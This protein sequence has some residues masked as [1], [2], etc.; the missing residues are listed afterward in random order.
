VADATARGRGPRLFGTLGRWI[1]R[2]PWYPIAFW[3]AL[4]IVAVP[5]L[6]LLGSVTTNS[7]TSLPATAP[8]S[9]ADR[10]LAEL[11]P[12]ESGGSS[13]YLLFTGPNLTD[14]N[15]QS[16]I[17]T[18][19]A[20]LQAD[21]K[22]TYVAG[23]SSVYTTYASYLG[24]EARI[25]SGAVQ[26]AAPVLVPSVNLSSTLLWGPPAL[27]L[28]TWQGL[29]RNGTSPAAANFPAYQE[30]AAALANQTQPLEVL[31]AFYVGYGSSGAG[32]NGSAQC[33]RDPT[34]TAVVACTDRTTRQNVGPLIGQLFPPDPSAQAVA[35]AALA[36][37]GVEN[38]T[39]YP[40][41]RATVA[42]LLV[43][44][45][46]LP[47]TWIDTVWTEFPHGIASPA[48]AAGW[49]NATVA[50]SS[51]YA[52]PLPI[53]YSISAQYVDPTGTASLIVVSFSVDD[54][55]TAPGGA[56]PVYNDITEINRIVPPTLAAADPS[57]AISFV[58]TGGSALDLAQQ[59]VLNQ[60]LGLV[61]PITVVLLMAITAL[62][63]RAPITPL[64]AF[65]G[66][67]IALVLSLGSTVLIGTF[68]T[69][70]DTSALTL[71][72]VFVLG[73]GTD[74]SIFLIARYREELIAGRASRE[75]VV[76][77]LTWAG[78]SVATSGTTAVIATL[79]LAFS[80]VALLS[81]WGIVLSV[82]ILIVMMASLTLTPALLVLIGPRIFWPATK[83][84]GR[85]LAEA[86]L[87]RIAGERTYFYRA[88]RL[89][90]RR[91]WTIV[92]IILLLSIPLIL[93]ALS[94]PV[95]YDY[96]GQLPTS[97]PAIQG[98]Q[99]L[100]G[101]YG[102]G[103]AFPSTALVTFSAPLLV[104][105]NR[106]NATEFGEIAAL[107]GIAESTSGIA[108]VRSP[109][110]PWGAPLATWTNFSTAP[111]AT[112]QNLRA[113]L[114]AYVGTDGRTVL[115]SLQTS[116]SGLS[117]D[118]IHTIQSVESSFATY[119]GV[120]PDVTHVAFG[121]A[122][123]VTSDLAAQTAEATER[124]I[125]AVAIGLIIVLFV[126][127]RSWIIPLMAVATIGLSILWS[128]ALT[129]LVLE[130][131]FGLALFF[132]VPTVLFILILGLGIDYNIFLLTRVR[133]ER[134]RGRS[135]SEATVQGVAR[136]GGIITAA[137]IILASAFASLLFGSF[138]LLVAIGFSVAIAVILDAMVVR[139]Y[140]VPAAMHLLGD[141]VWQLAPGRRRPEP[142]P[143]TV[144]E[145][146]AAGSRTN[147]R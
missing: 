76:T 43:P 113:L 96:Y 47:A 26:T 118:A 17:L 52:E 67:A 79:A 103:F 68:I 124:M 63:F 114:S 80:G 66:L 71:E 77:S 70:V 106:T 18:V 120:H 137:A 30:T 146:P 127:L 61:L 46:G 9:L 39:S 41:I 108:Q 38:Y 23:V 144:D 75:A 130:R 5:F 20:V 50:N 98:L 128:W 132:F 59:T 6:P 28:A 105:T 24:G 140:L 42:T 2:H 138:A 111:I 101:H 11:F 1:V 94:V 89:A 122:A 37:L 126:V 133:E 15:A 123:P 31:Q 36:T 74:Y 119:Q 78:Q 40:S 121:G 115:L 82:A 73:V 84:R 134:L 112:Q 129:Y 91:P 10:E 85:R 55:F 97:Q 34:P 88:G 33:A 117:E 95:S 13:T 87:D 7:T 32:F 27:F 86:Q 135:S 64:T 4:L 90:Q 99:T 21:P 131:I 44:T 104:G 29:V 58:Q 48:E 54:G 35:N 45:V 57:R 110:G 125:I 109:V 139:T 92:G 62:Y 49:A 116:V 12:N 100:G 147:Y 81:Q 72:E 56:T 14:P 143:T 8:S 141:R 53:P 25:A 60:S 93:V 83:D 3:I 19:T 102:P 136:T 142:A 69:Q 51:Y 65:V 16:T 145:A 107:T 22:L